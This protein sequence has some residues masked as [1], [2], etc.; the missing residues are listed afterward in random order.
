ML[1]VYRERKP[2]RAHA[3]GKGPR[4]KSLVISINS[5]WNIVNFRT[6]LID[7]IRREGWNVVALAPFDHYSSRLIEMGLEFEPLAIDSKSLSPLKDLLLLW[8]YWQMLRH[9]KPEVFLGYTIKPNIYGAWAASLLR[10]PVINNVS[11]LGTAF[12]SHGVIT[13]IVLQLYKIAFRQSRTVFFQ[14]YEDLGF[15]VER[16]IVTGEQARLLPGSGVDLAH[17]SFTPL[18]GG[19]RSVRFLFVGRLLGDKGIR[20]YV[21][22]ARLVRAR[23]PQATF[24]VLGF[25]DAAN[26]TAISQDELQAWVDDGVVEYLGAAEDVRPHIERAD[27]VVLP[28]YREGLSR[29]LLEA[30]AMGRPLIATDAPGCRDAVEDGVNGYL[31]EVRNPDSLA[32]AMNKLLSISGE[33]RA[34]LGRESRR[35]AEERF[36]LKIVIDRYLQAIRSAVT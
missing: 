31:C 11:G 4:P 5:S 30:A 24:A 15:F 34:A 29:A 23:F 3:G 17:F 26:R 8:R 22:A 35:I 13:R 14:N 10:I 2:S 32:D 28:S 20:E 18:P 27:C 7:A 6:G 21:K 1:S 16:R 19:N 33:R 36:D 25:L 9:I 12:I